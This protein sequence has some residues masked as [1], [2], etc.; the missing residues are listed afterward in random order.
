MN[1]FT[2][3]NEKFE[4]NHTFKKLRMPETKDDSIHNCLV[5]IWIESNTLKNTIWEKLTSKKLLN[6]ILMFVNK[7]Y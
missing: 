1:Q 2:K 6:T 7:W 3:F 4:L 5:T